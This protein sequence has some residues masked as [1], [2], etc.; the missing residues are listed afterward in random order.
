MNF[1]RR[2]RIFRINITISEIYRL[3]N[4]EKQIALITTMNAWGEK[5]LKKEPHELKYSP[6]TQKWSAWCLLCYEL[7][8][9]D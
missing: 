7:I 1:D 6:Q 2:D 5:I 8:N 9:I 3:P 4:Y